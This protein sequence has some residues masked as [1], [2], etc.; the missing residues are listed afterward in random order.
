MIPTL[1]MSSRLAISDH[2]RHA[3]CRNV[4]PMLTF[5]GMELD[6]AGAERLDPAWV[7]ER[8]GDPASR[9]LVASADGV[10]VSADAPVSLLRLSIPV[11]AGRA[12]QE[13]WPVLLGLEDGVALF[14]LDL[15]AA[16][17]QE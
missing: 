12:P 3:S 4:P 1:R 2:D 7:A 17:P 14:A 5:S 8:L 16:P 6:R 15:D 13:A 11:H 9:A 10:L